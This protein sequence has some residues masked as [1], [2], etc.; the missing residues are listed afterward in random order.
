MNK[1]PTDLELLYPN[2][3][4]ELIRRPDEPLNQGADG[5]IFAVPRNK[6]A[7]KLYHN[8]DK[9]PERPE[10]IRQMLLAPPDDNG[11]QHFAWPVAQVFKRQGG[12]VGYA[13]PLLPVSSY[14]SLDLLLTRK[15]RQLGKLPEHRDFRIKAASNLAR[16]VAQLHAKGHCI[17]DLKPANLLVHR[18]AADI[19][20]VDCDGFGVQGESAFIPGHQFTTGYIAP[21]SW[22]A[23]LKPEALDEEQDLFAL[24]VI[25]FQLLNEGLHPYQGIPAGKQ[26]IPGDTQ[27]RIGEGLYPYGVKPDA[28]ITPSPWSLH[29]DFPP[30]LEQ[31]FD[32]AFGKGAKR[33]HAKGWVSLLDQICKD[34]EICKENQTHAYWGSCCPLCE[35]SSVIIDVKKSR[36]TKRTKTKPRPAVYR[37]QN[38]PTQNQ[39][40]SR[41]GDSSP[42]F[43]AV[44]VVFSIFL[45]VIGYFYGLS[46]E[47]DRSRQEVE[48][49][50][51]AQQEY[52]ERRR[53]KLKAIEA[54]KVLN[55]WLEAGEPATAANV[56]VR[57]YPL[58]PRHLARDVSKA[59]RER[60]VPY[61]QPGAFSSGSAIP[62]LSYSPMAVTWEYTGKH[63]VSQVMFNL[64]TGELAQTGR[65]YI[66][67]NSEIYNLRDGYID[68]KSE[69]LYLR[70]C[71][72]Q[73]SCHQL[74]RITPDGNETSFQIG[75][76]LK[77]DGSGRRQQALSWRFAVTESE[78]Y[79]I[80]AG[81]DRLLVYRPDDPE[82]PVSEV[83]YPLFYSRHEVADL[84]V[85]P[86]GDQIYVGL[87]SSLRHGTEYHGAVLEFTID[88]NGQ[89][90]AGPDFS[91][92]WPDD[93]SKSA[94]TV[95]VSDDGNTLALGS[96]QE[97]RIDDST[98]TVLRE[99][100]SVGMARPGI[101][102]WK[103]EAGSDAWR[104]TGKYVL[105]RQDIIKTPL[106]SDELRINLFGQT[107]PDNYGFN[108]GF[109]LT[110]NGGRLLSGIEIHK[111][112]RSGTVARAWVLGIKDGVPKMQSRLQR[113][114]DEKGAYPVA[115]IS[116]NGKDATIGWV[117]FQDENRHRSFKNELYLGLTAFDLRS[118]YL[119]YR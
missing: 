85:T 71:G 94:A 97:F 51:K 21:E 2:G 18:K 28:R 16:R 73:L 108:I 46:E 20:V 25:I 109:D 19:V 12:F 38:P 1:A 44:S 41:S 119:V 70:K 5:A 83:K 77:N 90:E 113:G 50:Q 112:R 81:S 22:N 88:E 57:S 69:S 61:F 23:Q 40:G 62:L 4:R 63:P 107:L 111:K 24:A 8:P 48:Q 56:H 102:I 42:L 58:P 60:Q 99:A 3:Q 82:R 92:M 100:V 75:H 65:S 49:R 89:A 96:Y 31:A 80:I 110:S 30:Q 101:T 118:S 68:P 91:V 32:Q 6:L 54:E 34:L 37:H 55:G 15:G 86:N 105:H 72:Y 39:P 79:I 76:E 7:L 116:T 35:Q 45:G 78:R 98:Y 11:L 13:M 53:Q 115:A 9:D 104:N 10:K 106:S 67:G 27:N 14:A 84:A 95:D 66:L 36:S 52:A 103:K 87:V 33:L 93:G 17:I 43:I 59:E 114:Y 47:E 26:D 74:A 64:F 117:H 29:R